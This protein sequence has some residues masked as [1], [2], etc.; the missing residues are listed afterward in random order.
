M[1]DN[2]NI[3]VPSFKF[4]KKT[5]GFNRVLWGFVGLISMFIVGIFGFVFHE[6]I[7][8]I[9][10]IIST[11]FSDNS[12]VLW[13]IF[14]LIFALIF[15][16]GFYG[17]INSLLHS[18]KFENGKII[19]GK[20][21]NAD[22]VKGM[23]L[24]LDSLITAY[25]IE[26][27]D[28]PTNIMYANTLKNSFRI[29]NLIQLNTDKKFV[30]KYFD[31]PLYKKK[32]YINP[33]L[34]KETKYSLIYICDNSKKLKILKIYDGMN[35][36]RMFNKP[37]SLISRILIRSLIVFLIFSAFSLCDLIIGY[38]NNTQYR[39]LINSTYQHIE[40]HLVSYGYT[41]KKI[42]EKCYIFK[43]DSNG[44]NSH[45]KYMFNKNGDIM[46]VE[47]D[48]YFSSVSNTDELNFIIKS[49]NE[50]FSDNE[51]E[52]FI[53][54]VDSCIKGMCSYTKL[55]SDKSTIRIGTSN[56]LIQVHN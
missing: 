7:R 47:F 36:N 38:S 40:S 14:I 19:K 31:T 55:V 32:E 9:L 24:T 45:L 26:H 33:K 2:Q 42:N 54:N 12:I 28:S 25:M 29:I 4:E 3:F 27:M 43:K 56:G 35:I 5:R 46:D 48:I 41:P 52:N 51:I 49:M 22:R 11:F 15:A 18:Y 13:P 30:T 8:Y 23:D 1:N 10:N 37:R 39:N 21:L 44:R 20:I 53:S 17:F 6:I 50:H 16:I 34:L